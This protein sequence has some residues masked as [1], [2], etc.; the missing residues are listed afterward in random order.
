[1]PYA[2]RHGTCTWLAVAVRLKSQATS[3]PFP[4]PRLA[5][6][7]FTIAGAGPSRRDPS[8]AVRPTV[9]PLLRKYRHKKVCCRRPGQKK[10][11]GPEPMPCIRRALPSLFRPIG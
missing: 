6:C 11:P 9:F 5:T 1:M 8:A 7:Y 2:S 10:Y 4:P 3:P